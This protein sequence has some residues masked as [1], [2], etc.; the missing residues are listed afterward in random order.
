MTEHATTP[1]RP[2]P[3]TDTAASATAATATGT[4]ATATG[5]A[6]SATGA[7]ATGTAATGVAVPEVD[8]TVPHSARIWN[9]W[10]GG[11]DNYPVDRA[12][13]EQTMRVL[14]E[15]VDI[16]RHSRAFLGRAVLYLAGEAGIRQFL[17][18]GAGLPTVDNTHEAAQQVAPECRVVYVDNDPLVL[19][20]AQQLLT[21]APQGMTDYVHADVRDPDAVLRAASQTLDLTRPVGI[22]MLGILPFIGDDA[23]AGAIVARLLDAVPE[24]SHLA[25]T[26]STSVVTGDRVVEAVRQWNAVA[27]AP[28]HLRTPG[29]MARFFDGLTLVDPGIVSCPRWRPDLISLHGL[30]EM[31]EFCAVGRK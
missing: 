23:E 16:A 2:Q 10:L 24:G 31:D 20:H 12:V 30:P 25:I 7:A 8:T 6:A 14:P 11:E 18:L 28:Y 9:Y 3:A 19:A 15:I 21:S 4:A 1:D 13:G 26:H 29:Q 5:T 17:D 27:P 22:I